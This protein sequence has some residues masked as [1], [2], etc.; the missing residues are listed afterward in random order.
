MEPSSPQPS[1]DRLSVTFAVNERGHEGDIRREACPGKV[2][3]E[4]NERDAE[5]L[6]GMQ[7]IS[8]TG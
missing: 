1:V 5:E 3:E 7:R 4:G 2:Q 8:I 6:A